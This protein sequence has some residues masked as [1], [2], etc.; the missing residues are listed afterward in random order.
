MT[1]PAQSLAALNGWTEEAYK[2]FWHHMGAVFGRPWYE[3]N[4]PEA[5]D[6]WMREVSE[7]SL[8]RMAA[9]LRHFRASGDHYP[10][11][12]SV[13]MKT[14][15]DIKLHVEQKAL[16]H[17]AP[18]PGVVED[19][20]KRIRA[21][22]KGQRRNVLKPDESFSDVTARAKSGMDQK[23]FDAQRMI[24]NGW[25][26]EEEIRFRQHAATCGYRLP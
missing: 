4:G 22:S 6:V 7:I 17:A 23:E 16:P 8:D 2:R 25:T 11:N 9:T 19:A 1:V 20:I 5:T 14:A 18:T 12:L 21:T 24:E 26:P 3:Q 10:P 15:R 13:F